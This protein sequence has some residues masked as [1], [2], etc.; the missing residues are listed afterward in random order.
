MKGRR[1]EWGAHTTDTDD[2]EYLL[3]DVEKG[4]NHGNDPEQHHGPVKV[5]SHF[6]W[7]VGFFGF[8]CSGCRCEVLGGVV[9]RLR[10]SV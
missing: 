10:L 3:R 9:K 2:A 5:L 1:G 7:R 4:G 6:D 8:W